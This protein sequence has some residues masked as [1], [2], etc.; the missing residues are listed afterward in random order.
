M[1]GSVGPAPLARRVRSGGVASTTGA[2]AASR[3]PGIPRS[4]CAER[5]C[6]FCPLWPVAVREKRGVTPH[7][8][9]SNL[10][11]VGRVQL[12][13]ACWSGSTGLT[14]D[15]YDDGYTSIANIDISKIVIDQM[16]DRHRD[17]AGLTCTWT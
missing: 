13:A 9:G 11:I 3:R 14:E 10:G 4:P 15:M 16:T 2:F 5:V 1:A 12:T 8:K 6:G 7:R 17:K